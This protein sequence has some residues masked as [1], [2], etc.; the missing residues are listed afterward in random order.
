GDG[1]DALGPADLVAGRGDVRVER[2][3]LCFERGDLDASTRQQPAQSGDHRALA[4]VTV[5][6]TDHEAGHG[7]SVTCGFAVPGGAP[8]PPSSGAWGPPPHARPSTCGFAVPGGAPTPPS[9]GAWGPPPHARPS[10]V[11][12]ASSRRARPPSS[13]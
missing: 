8:T 1:L 12:S 13:G 6:A 9:S 3:V 10:S 7:A 2:H 11:C 5:G 4:G